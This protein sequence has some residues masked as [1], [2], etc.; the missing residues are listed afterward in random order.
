MRRELLMRTVI[1][2]AV[3]MLATAAGAQQPPTPA[4]APPPPPPAE[5]TD[6]IPNKVMTAEEKKA[7]CAARPTV[8]KK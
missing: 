3:A 1:M 7:W 5:T 6:A 8:C 4:P 2:I